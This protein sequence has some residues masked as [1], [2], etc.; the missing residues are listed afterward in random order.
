[1]DAQTVPIAVET[2]EG[3]RMHNRFSQLVSYYYFDR[4]NVSRV[5]PSLCSLSHRYCSCRGTLPCLPCPL[6]F[7][8]LCS[9]VFS[10]WYGWIF[11][12]SGR[13]FSF[14][15][16]TTL[17]ASWSTPR[18]RRPVLRPMILIQNPRCRK[19][20]QQCNL[21]GTSQRICLPSSNVSF[22]TFWKL[23]CCLPCG[24]GHS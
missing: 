7:H 18:R 23:F 8:C 12:T 24:T 6:G 21:P 14:L 20:P 1:M 5:D 17:A 10:T 16:D 11:A 22:Q 15:T 13:V 4:Q 2:I 3:A 9:R 19:R